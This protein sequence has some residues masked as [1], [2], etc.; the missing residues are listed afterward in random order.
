M[1][2]CAG[3]LRHGDDEHKVEQEFQRAS[4]HFAEDD[5]VAAQVK[6]ARI[7]TVFRYAHVFPRALALMASGRINVRPLITDRFAFTEGVAAFDY[8][9]QMNPT[10]VKV[11]IEMP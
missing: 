11:Q 1:V 3:G 8:A 10:S 7:E 4:G 6:E 2:Q 9:C 5:I